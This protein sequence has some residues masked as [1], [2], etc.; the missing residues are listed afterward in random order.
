MSNDGNHV[1]RWVLPVLLAVVAAA[2]VPTA[3]GRTWIVEKDGSG[4]FTVIQ[5][6]V[7]AASNGDVIEIGPGRY[8]EYQTVESGPQLFD[9]H[10][11]VPE[12]LQITFVGSG[13]EETVI[14]PEDPT[15]HEN[16][17]YGIA[18]WPDVDIVVRDLGIENCDGKD[19]YI[20][21][22]SLDVQ[23]CR[24][25]FQ[26]EYN[27]DT[28]GIRGSAT[29][30]CS[31]TIRDCEFI[32]EFYGIYTTVSPGGVVVENCVFDGC[33]GGIYAGSTNS[34]DVRVTDSWFGCELVGIGFIGGGGG[35]IHRCAFENCILSFESSGSVIVTES[36]VTRDDGGYLA[37]RLQN[38]DPVVFEDNVFQSNGTVIFA[39]SLG[40]GTFRNNHF[41]QTGD[42]Y[43]IECDDGTYWHSD[44]DLSGNYWGTTD[45]DEIA[46]GIY[47]C[48]DADDTYHCVIFEPLAD[49]VAVES[50][51]WSAIK[52]LF[53]S[54]NG[55]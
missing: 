35:E 48:E 27:W 40:L 3:E 15:V 39:R 38:W 32:G 10:V 29:T 55:E 17:A 20:E 2:A 25:E 47:D 12:G 43:T 23:R 44:L 46:A 54:G 11:I 45:V 1:L 4:D 6:A 34:G 37:V 26:G 36:T 51:T 41:L 9:L 16:E 33:R 19:I 5:D 24:F 50:R 52:G 18:G 49:I 42:G 22:G 28:V 7:D 31:M 30:G 13:A 21:S 14:G 8:E 53:D